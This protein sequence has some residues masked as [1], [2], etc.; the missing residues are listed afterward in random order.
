MVRYSALVALLFCT[1]CASSTQ[2]A[3]V[4]VCPSMPAYSHDFE[5]AAAAQLNS[6]P[7]DSPL[8]QMIRD[9]IAVRQEIRD[10]KP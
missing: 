7:S 8:S 9:Y 10:C 2:T 1:G 4:H 6:L 5:K 3:Y